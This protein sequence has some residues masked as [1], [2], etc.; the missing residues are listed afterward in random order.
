M[1]K[2]R[3]VYEVTPTDQTMTEQNLQAKAKGFI[4]TDIGNKIADELNINIIRE[5]ATTKY[6]YGR[7]Y[8]DVSFEPEN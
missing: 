2:I 3:S 7:F 4:A 1:S 5:A 6:P 8:L